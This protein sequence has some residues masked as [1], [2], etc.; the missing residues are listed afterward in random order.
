MD[1]NINRYI[2]NRTLTICFLISFR[3]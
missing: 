2:Y 3:I 1:M